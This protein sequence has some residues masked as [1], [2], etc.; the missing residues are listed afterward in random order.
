MLRQTSSP[1]ASTDN[2]RPYVGRFAPSPSGPLH[3]GSLVC[4]LASYLH[5]KQAQGKWLVRIEDIDVQRTSNEMIRA[6]A[7]SLKAHGMQW[8][9]SDDQGKFMLVSDN[10]QLARTIDEDIRQDFP[11]LS[12]QSQRYGLYEAKL[13]QLQASNSVYACKC[14]RKE[15]SARAP[16]YDRHCRGL[17]LP[18]KQFAIRWKNDL[19]RESFDDLHVGTQYV[20]ERMAK[21]D[22][23][24]KR[25]DGMYAYHLAVVADDIEQGVTHIVRGSDL[26]ETSPIQI[27]L[28]EAL[29]AQAPVYFHIPVASHEPG[30]KL[31]K[32]NLAPAIDNTRALDNL[33]SSLA[34]L[35]MQQKDYAHITQIDALL[36]WAIAHWQPQL[37]SSQTEILVLRTNGVYCVKNPTQSSE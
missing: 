13:A 22:P 34:F 25:A 4:A 35:G 8:D 21:E 11:G 3:F 20:N 9:A 33:K 30:Q 37:L 7:A 17:N 32:Q 36:E 1:S 26:I 24:L 29:G 27:S 6:I 31:S 14:S 28:F 2:H 12:Y 23:V 5:A 15:I 10:S 19:A 18:F 16:Y